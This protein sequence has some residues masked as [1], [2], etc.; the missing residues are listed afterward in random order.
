MSRSDRDRRRRRRGAA[1]R[2]RDESLRI[3][4]TTP[5]VPYPP[6]Y[7]G[8][9][10]SYHHLRGL[11]ERGHELV[12]ILPLR[13]EGDRDG[14]RVLGEIGKVRA[15]PAAMKSPPQFLLEA[16]ASGTS[17]RIARHRFRAVEAETAHALREEKA[18]DAVYLDT[19]FST[20]LVPLFRSAIP[21]APV[22]LLEL[23]L[24]SQVV[25][26]LA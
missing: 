26:R 1:H 6:T 23:N 25:E 7:G 20:Y 10:I 14:A 13:R 18:F 19:L 12:M 4:Y 15:V 22:V 24:E 9:M 2:E 16:L 3:L 5:F 17:L 8:T 21:A 11:A